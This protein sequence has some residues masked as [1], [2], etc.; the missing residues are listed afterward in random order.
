MLIDQR[1]SNSGSRP[2]V[3]SPAGDGGVAQWQLGRKGKKKKLTRIELHQQ[4]MCIGPVLCRQAVG[5]RPSPIHIYAFEWGL[6]WG[7]ASTSKTLSHL[8]I[9]LLSTWI[10]SASSPSLQTVSLSSGSAFLHAS[11][12]HTHRHTHS[13]WCYCVSVTASA[14]Y[15]AVAASP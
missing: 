9:N 10:R 7:L 3:G 15:A 11:P 1:F 6:G 4:Y 13:L 8:S 12:T 14:C 5:G 2:Q